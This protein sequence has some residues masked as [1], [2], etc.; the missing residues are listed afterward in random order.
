ML[1][2]FEG[3]ARQ[4]DGLVQERHNSI[5]DALELWLSYT[6]L[7]IFTFWISSRIWLDPSRWNELW[8]SRLG[9]KIQIV[10]PTQPMLCLLMFRWLEEASALA[11]M[12]F[13]PKLKYSISSIRSVDFSCTGVSMESHNHI[14]EH[15]RIVLYLLNLLILISADFMKYKH[16][17][18]EIL[19]L[20]FFIY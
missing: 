11:G 2:C 9:T 1:N 3:F 16:F 4:I 20:C 6:N 14:C 5:A 8:N 12:V 19:H 18:V 13:T 7:S 10:F 15:W 17:N